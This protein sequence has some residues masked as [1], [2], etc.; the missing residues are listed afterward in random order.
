MSAVVRAAGEGD[1]PAVLELWS[2]ARS[3]HAS[4][5]DSAVAVQRLLADRPDALLV[6]SLDDAIVGAL[7]AA[8][9]GWRGNMYRLAVHPEHRRRGVALALVREGERR[10]GTAGIVRI[11]ALV[12]HDDAVARR[13]WA[14]VGYELDAEIG[15]F[16]RNL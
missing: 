9:D 5:P 3:G 1:V 14:T 12:A 11:T 2:D 6:A 15:R 10:L 16:V 4:T 7:I 13:L 8:S